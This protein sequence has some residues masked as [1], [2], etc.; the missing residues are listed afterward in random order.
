[1]TETLGQPGFFG[2]LETM[3]RGAGRFLGRA[4][5][6]LMLIA[7]AVAALV[8]TTVIGFILALA[9]MFLTLGHKL[10]RSRRERAQPSDTLD[11]RQTPDGWVIETHTLSSR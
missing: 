6:G 2:R 7:A 11:A 8:A 5:F 3:A 1:M 9:A 4:G 10:G